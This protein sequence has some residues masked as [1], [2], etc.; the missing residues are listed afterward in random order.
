M[1]L[2]SA[3]NVG[4]NLPHDA[5]RRGQIVGAIHPATGMPGVNSQIDFVHQVGR[6]QVMVRAFAS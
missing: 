5:G 1:R 3:S 2:T 4:E 6:L